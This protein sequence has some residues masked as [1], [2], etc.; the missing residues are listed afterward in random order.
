VV[1]SLKTT[2]V[3]QHTYKPSH[4]D[5]AELDKVCFLSKNLYN[6]TLYEARQAFFD[7]GRF[8]RYESINKRFTD[9]S[10]R[11]YT[12][13]PRKVSKLTQ[14]LVDRGITSY[15]GLVREWKKGKIADRPGL[16]RYLPKDG[17]Q[18]V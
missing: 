9:E 3:E 15:Y 16:P 8:E 6:A 13:L 14:K 18:V 12:A 7:T 17:R 2:L 1:G 11:D 10:Q 4:P 5:Y